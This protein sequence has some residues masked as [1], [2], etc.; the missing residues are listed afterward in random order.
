[1]T[2]RPVILCISGSVRRASTNTALLQA[3]AAHCADLAQFAFARIGDLPIF[4]PDLEGE[5]TPPVVE[6]FAR[7]VADSAG[8]LFAVPEYAHGIPGGLKNALDWLVSRSEFPDKPMMMVHASTRSEHARSSLAEVLRTMS[9]RLV[10]EDGLSLGLM[11]KSEEE[12][13]ALLAAKETRA[14]M[15][16]A[17]QTLLAEIDRSARTGEDAGPLLES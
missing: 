12:L 11:G 6:Q 3:L 1:M 13:A 16:A 17:V 14:Q 10:S 4:N 9:G 8:L 7:S 2:D 15:R 5:R